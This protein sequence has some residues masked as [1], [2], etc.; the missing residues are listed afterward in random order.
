MEIHPLPLKCD[1]TIHG[2]QHSLFFKNDQWQLVKNHIHCLLNVPWQH[3][4]NCIHWFLKEGSDK[5]WKITS[6][7]WW[8]N[9]DNIL[10]SIH[11]LLHMEN[12]IHCSFKESSDNMCKTTSTSL[13]KAV[14]TY[15]R[16]S[17]HGLLNVLWEHMENNIHCLLN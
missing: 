4:E 13:W 9:S 2:K 1:V 5:M 8:N 3:K 15:V 14:T 10:K 16:K 17:I 11:C 12:N 7:A 6:A